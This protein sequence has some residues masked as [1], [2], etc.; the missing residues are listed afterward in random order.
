MVHRPAA[1]LV[2]RCANIHYID[3]TATQ[4]AG[5]TEAVSVTSANSD[6]PHI[7]ATSAA[8]SAARPSKDIVTTVAAAASSSDVDSIDGGTSYRSSSDSS[9][10][11]SSFEHTKTPQL[12]TA[13]ARRRY[14]SIASATDYGAVRHNTKVSCMPT[15]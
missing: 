2:A 3:T 15:D 7:S 6:S 8:T 4:T 5:S 13:A 1:A 14:K 9:S 11:S 12:N 10:E